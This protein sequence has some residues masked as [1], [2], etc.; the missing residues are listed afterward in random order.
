MPARCLWVVM[1]AFSPFLSH[2]GSTC[3]NPQ[4]CFCIAYFV[5]HFCFFFSRHPVEIIISSHTSWHHALIIFAA[6]VMPSGVPQSTCSPTG[7][8]SW[9]HCV[10]LW[11]TGLLAS[12]RTSMWPH[13]NSHQLSSTWGAWPK[14]SLRVHGGDVPSRDHSAQKV[15]NS[16]QSL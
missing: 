16:N 3:P 10:C 13:G 15:G 9:V 14:F 12:S 2:Q 7:T 1:W 6:R 4:L 11:W 8:P 5:K